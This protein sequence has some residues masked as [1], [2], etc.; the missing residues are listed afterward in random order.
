MNWRKWIV[1]VGV[2]V[3]ATAV[4]VTLIVRSHRWRPRIITI[5][6]AIIRKDADVRKELPIAGAAVI[7]TDGLMTVRT[8]SDAS[9][10]F[11][12]QFRESVWPGQTVTLSFRSPDYESYDLAIHPGIRSNAKM[13]YVAKLSPLPQSPP[14]RTARKMSVISNIRIRYTVNSKGDYNIASAVKT[15]QVVN[16]GNVPCNRQAPCSPD[17]LWK[18][19]TGSVTLDAGPDH[20]YRNVRASCI[21]GPCPFT[22]IDSS[23]YSQGG[24]VITA[25]ALDWSDTATFLL[26]AEVFRSAINSSVRE[27]Y[28]VIFGKTLNFTLPPTEEGV[29]I[30]AE[31]DGTPMVF[32]LG[33]DLNL[34]WAVCSARANREGEHST[35]YRCELKPGFKFS[36]SQAQE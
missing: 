28:P 22:R 19:N 4:I 24:R 10:Y 27:S 8:Q 31:M 13:L 18:A 17:G 5:Q 20:E 15:F 30:E 12:L 2:A 29:S 1:W 25:T 21:A 7:A 3:A 14:P 34:S 9:G 36:D 35:V 11:T 26:E 6:G 23:G 33:P 32:P 16:Q